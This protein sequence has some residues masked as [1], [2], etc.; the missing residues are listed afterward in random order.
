MEPKDHY[1][2]EE[3]FTATYQ[4]PEVMHAKEFHMKGVLEEHEYSYISLR[5]TCQNIL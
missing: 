4:Q 1:E 3:G 5:E 2:I